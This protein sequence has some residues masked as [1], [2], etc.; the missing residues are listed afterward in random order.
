MR[1]IELLTLPTEACLAGGIGEDRAPGEVEDLPLLGGIVELDLGSADH[2]EA[3]D[4]AEI[5]QLGVESGSG[6][7]GGEVNYF[8]E[9][10]RD[11]DCCFCWLDWWRVV[12]LHVS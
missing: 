3:A 4:L 10:G 1:L 9:R 5:D 6:A 7:V 11:H 12:Q 8:G 2:F